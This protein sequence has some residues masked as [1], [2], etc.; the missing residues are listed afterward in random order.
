MSSTGPEF[1]DIVGDDLAPGEEA[2]LRRVHELLLAAGPPPE[3]PPALA[4]PPAERGAKVIGFPVRRRLGVA[5]VLAAALAAAAFGGGYFVGDRGSGWTTE[6]NPIAMRG[7][8]PAQLASIRLAPRDAAGNWPLLLRVKGLP[9]LPNGGYYELLLT[10]NGK[11]G[12]S[13]GTFRVHGTV[14]KIVLN[15]PYRLKAWDG[16]VIVA[17]RTGRPESR[18]ILST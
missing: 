18:P 4:E 10:K 16:W 5:V 7:A 15:A 14:T 6:G 8:S 12:P 13:C 1:R 2:Q 9:E 17:H 3:L 11:F